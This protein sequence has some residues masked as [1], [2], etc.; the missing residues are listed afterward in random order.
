MKRSISL[1]CPLLVL[2]CCSTTMWGQSSSVTFQVDMNQLEE[3]TSY[4]GIFLNAS[5]TGWC[6][7]CDPMSDPDNDGVWTVTKVLDYGTYEYKFSIDGWNAQEWFN[8]GE[9]CTSTIDGYTNRTLVVDAPVITL[10]LACF[11][12]CSPCMEALGGCTYPS[13]TNYNPLA[14]VDDQTCTFNP[15]TNEECAADLNNDGSVSTADLLQFLL[16]FGQ[17]C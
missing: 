8:E 7:G 13:A 16:D 10:D 9:A 14:T 15:T 6:G 17:I 1:L 12:E 3:P 11:S 5:F 4:G 2:L